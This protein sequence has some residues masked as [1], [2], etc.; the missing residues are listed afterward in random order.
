MV[1]SNWHH[2]ATLTTLI[3]AALCACFTRVEAQSAEEIRRTLF[4]VE[5][6]SHQQWLDGNVAAL[7]TLMAD[8]PLEA[9]Q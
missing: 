8:E 2:P 6:A 7:D 1:R 5:A 9:T 4:A 3:T